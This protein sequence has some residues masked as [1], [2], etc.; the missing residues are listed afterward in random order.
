M[1]LKLGSADVYVGTCSWRDHTGF[2]PEG[3][4]DPDKIRFYA[5]RF[6]FVEVDSSYYSM[7][8]YRNCAL[9]NER[10]PD[11]FRFAFKAYSVMTLQGRR[12]GGKRVREQPTERMFRDFAGAL[13]PLRQ[14][15]KLAYVLFQFPDWF[16][17]WRQTEAGVDPLAYIATCGEW[18]AGIPIAVEFRNGYWLQGTSA[19][20]TLDLL[21]EREIAY[22]CVDEPQVGV[23]HSAPPVAGTTARLSVV[24]FH[25]RRADVW[26]KRD[27]GVSERFAYEYSVDELSQW[28]PK[29]AKLASEAQEVYVGFNNCHRDFAVKNANQLKQLL[30]ELE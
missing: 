28:V 6:P 29:L 7:P 19:K 15:G 1:P 25:G 24:R 11:G 16:Y 21:R 5:E 17:P 23:A 20:R 9:W 3:L 26:A 27:V 10:T 30:L 14:A 22:T 13:E 4:P 12:E 18:M 2:Y 8:S